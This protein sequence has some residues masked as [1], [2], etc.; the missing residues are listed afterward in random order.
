MHGEYD[1]HPANQ[2]DE[3]PQD[4]ETIDGDNI[5]VQERRPRTNRTKPHEHGQI[6]KH[7]NGW[8]KRVVYGFKAEPITKSVSRGM[9]YFR[10]KDSYS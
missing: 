5:I 9:E 4:D 8:L 7:I 6:E 2:E 1:R 10:P 3:D